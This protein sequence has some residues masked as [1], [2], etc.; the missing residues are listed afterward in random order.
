MQKFL[1]YTLCRAFC[2]ALDC[3]FYFP[4][5]HVKKNDFS[6]TKGWGGRVFGPVLLAVLRRSH[7]RALKGLGLLNPSSR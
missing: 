4:W 5:L 7:D 2:Q 6:L 1:E 3:F